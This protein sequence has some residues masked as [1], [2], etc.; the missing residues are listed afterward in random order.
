MNVRRSMGVVVALAVINA[1]CAGGGDSDLE[2]TDGLIASTVTTTQ[3]QIATSRAAPGVG[4][5]TI[6]AT[7]TPGAAAT[8]A[9]SGCELMTAGPLR[10]AR[11]SPA[12][13]YFIHHPAVGSADA[14]TVMFIPGGSTG[15]REAAQRVWANYLS[16]GHGV[17][18]YRVVIPY[19][20]DF[21]LYDDPERILLIVDEVLACFG[22]DPSQ[23]HIA[24]YSRGGQ[25]AFDLM[26]RRPDLFATVLGAPGEFQL[27]DPEQWREKL[28]GKAVFNGVGADDSDWLPFVKATHAGLVEAGINSV[29]VE[30]PGE[31]HRLSSEFD[32][33]VFFSFWASH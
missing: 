33:S 13:P 19:A 27:I 5:T 1:G 25:I 20:V 7:T 3:A 11:R 14:P 10:E 8:T 32:E 4:A 9:Q 6:T 26:L 17:N 16:G 28:A 22:G 12:S 21:D 2:D 23:V 30:F 29:Y 15:T 18:E 24:G 31:G